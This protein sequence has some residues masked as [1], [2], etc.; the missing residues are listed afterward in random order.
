[1]VGAGAAHSG[2]FEGIALYAG[3]EYGAAQLGAA[4]L[5]EKLAW[6]QPTVVPQ[7]RLAPQQSMEQQLS[8]PE[9]N[10]PP[11]VQLEPQGSQPHGS[12]ASMP[13]RLLLQQQPVAASIR[14]PRR[15]SAIRRMTLS[16]SA[17]WSRQ[18]QAQA[19]PALLPL[20]SAQPAKFLELS[21]SEPSPRR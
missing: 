19:G 6:P 13:H 9:P 11:E 5:G 3:M 8:Q 7:P 1:V 15:P 16:H 17:G 4:Q 2:Q 10:S 14:H 21:Q 18:T 20:E 12:Q